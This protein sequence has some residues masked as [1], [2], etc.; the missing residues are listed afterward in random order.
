MLGLALAA[1]LMLAFSFPRTVIAERPTEALIR[2]AFDA[3]QRNEFATA[4]DL[5]RAAF[6][7]DPR[8][9]TLLNIAAT[10]E[11]WAGHACDAVEAFDRYLS[12]CGGRTCKNFDE[13]KKRRAEL[14]RGCVGS[15]EI[16]THPAGA[17]TFFDDVLIGTSPTSTTTWPGIHRVEIRRDN[18]LPLVRT[19]TIAAGLIH[20]WSFDLAPRPALQV[21]ERASVL[22]GEVARNSPPTWPKWVAFGLSMTALGVA[23]IA[24]IEYLNDTSEFDRLERAPGTSVDDLRPAA[25]GIDLERVVAPVA[26]ATSAVALA[27]GMLL[28]SLE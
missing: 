16:T 1:G 6:E 22:E 18:F 10:Y 15:V 24:G 20:R 3:Y 2:Q 11:R 26:F 21:A 12:A 13:G 8:P 5:F 14:L 23:A 9:L 17:E 25:R 4:I 27:A 28:W 19:V 7:L